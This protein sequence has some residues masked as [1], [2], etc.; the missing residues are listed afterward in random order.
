M[1]LKGTARHPGELA[2][3]AKERFE[4]AARLVGRLDFHPVLAVNLEGALDEHFGRN[5]VFAHGRKREHRRATNVDGVEFLHLLR[6]FHRTARRIFVGHGTTALNMLCL[7]SRFAAA[8]LTQSAQDKSQ[9][10]ERD[11]H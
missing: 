2:D 5:S 11:D 10:H 6:L 8:L 1:A 9:H 7:G 3:V 4:A